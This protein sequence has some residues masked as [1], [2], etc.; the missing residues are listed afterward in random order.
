[1]KSL[2]LKSDVL[3]PHAQ[4]NVKIERIIIVRQF[5]VHKHFK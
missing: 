3:L 2:N 1:M 4:T 5:N